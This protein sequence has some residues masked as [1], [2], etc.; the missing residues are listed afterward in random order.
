M[1][2]PGPPLI[3]AQAR[4]FKCQKH[5]NNRLY[6]ATN[7]YSENLLL[8]QRLSTNNSNYD[9]PEIRHHHEWDTVHVEHFSPKTI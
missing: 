5:N 4:N 3:A 7:Y 8:I 1:L 9:Y 6:N 2:L